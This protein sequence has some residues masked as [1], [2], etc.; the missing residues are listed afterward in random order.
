[1]GLDDFASDDDSTD[2]TDTSE[3]QSQSNK[4]TESTVDGVNQTLADPIEE[5]DMSFYGAADGN[6]GTTPMQRKGAMTNHSMADLVR[7]TD[8]EMMFGED[9]VK[10][11]LHI[12][13]VFT[14]DRE[15]KEA[16]RYQ[17]TY[18]HD[19]PRPAWHGKVVSCLAVIETRLGSMNKELAMFETGS[20]SKKRVM[21]TFDSNLGQNLDADTQIY[22]N[23]FGDVFFL[24]DLAQADEEFR[25]GYMI[26]RDEVMSKVIR[27]KQL[28]SVLE[29]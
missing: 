14:R 6:P 17:L 27:P 15:Y 5:N 3:E 12:F 23:F 7:T 29:K 25:E 9:Y 24:R 13:T 11:H 8:G 4:E 18:P 19:P 21:E 20:T 28:R 1:M 22:I 10:L 26:D 16:N 2:S